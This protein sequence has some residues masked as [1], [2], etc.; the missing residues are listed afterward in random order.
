MALAFLSFLIVAEQDSIR[1]A[2]VLELIPAAVEIVAATSAS[3]GADLNAGLD[4]YLM[5]FTV[6]ASSAAGEDIDSGMVAKALGRAT[7]RRTPSGVF[8]CQRYRAEISP[9]CGS[10]RLYL[11]L[12]GL[13]VSPLHAEVT[14]G[15]VWRA[16]VSTSRQSRTRML[17]VRLQFR[18][19]TGRWVMTNQEILS[20]T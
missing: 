17:S 19:E 20:Q 6:L 2:M 9:E 7:S 13:L 1:R 12:V 18:R 16:P 10:S 14:L 4:V 11:E 3:Q 8:W 15:A 5:S